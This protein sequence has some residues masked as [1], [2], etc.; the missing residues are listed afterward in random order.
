[1]K[2]KNLATGLFI[3]LISCHEKNRLSNYSLRDSVVQDY[4]RRADSTQEFDTTEVNYK[5]LKAYL[6][7]DTNFFLQFKKQEAFNGQAQHT[8]D[9]I[10]SFLRRPKLRMLEA[11]EAYRFSY[12]MAFC[13]YTLD[14]TI[15]KKDSLVNLHF[16]LYEYK[17]DA[18]NGRVINEYDKKLTKSDW[19]EFTQSLS[20]ADFWG[21]KGS[22][23][24]S[25]LDGDDIIVWGYIK[26]DTS[27][28]RPPR[29]NVVSRWVVHTTTLGDPFDLAL[30]LSDNSQG[31]YTV[32][33]KKGDRKPRRALAL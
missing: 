33:K 20:H 14:V 26:G 18:T 13:P 19:G 25:G 3:V 10:D 4:L 30:I 22:N 6:R 24:I 8:W 32:R 9:K 1:M 28:Q 23:G 29:F 17:W 16:I 2:W 15:S 27:F 12:R 7:S 5:L 11:D 21:L 31:C